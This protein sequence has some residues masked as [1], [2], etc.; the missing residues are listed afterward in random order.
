MCIQQ[1]HTNVLVDIVRELVVDGN[2]ELFRVANH[3][4]HGHVRVETELLA[5]W[6]GCV[7]HGVNQ[8]LQLW[9][10]RI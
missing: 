9:I 7:V 5:E 10:W 8:A 2:C 4:A 3:I 1:R 6:S